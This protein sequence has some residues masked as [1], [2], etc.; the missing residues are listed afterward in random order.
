MMPVLSVAVRRRGLT[1]ILLDT[2]LM[3]GGFFMVIPL[4]AVYYVD[5]LGW[6]ATTIGLVLAV[7]QALQQ[8]LTVIGGALADRFG[9]RRLIWSGLLVRAISFAGLA[10]ADTAP[11]LLATAVL[12]AVGGGL[13]ESPRQA[14]IAAL[15]AP[16]ERRR[17]FALSGVVGGLGMTLGPLLGAALL[18]V[19]FAAVSLVASACFVVAFLVTL[20]ALPPV[21]IA[22]EGRGLTAGVREALADRPFMRYTGL[23]MGYWFLWVQLTIA[24]PLAGRALAGTAD[25]VGWI[26]ALN[27]GMMVCLQLPVLRL[28]ER[29]FSPRTSL[30]LGLVTMAGG[31][32]LI[33]LT[34]SLVGLLVCVAIF[35]FGGLL[36]GPSQ[37]SVTAALANPKALGSYF[38][39]NAL[40]MAFGGGLGNIA[41]GV[42]VDL[43]AAWVLP[44]LPWLVCGVVGLATAAGLSRLRIADH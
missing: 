33:A 30:V 20:V 23:L 32:T 35:S 13:F 5:H 7:R 40:A 14:V 28:V 24:V 38:G 11:A 10:W 31:L 36:A 16:A 18:R 3:F 37:Q 27:A 41:G 19:D 6:A 15:T 4:L 25:V 1:I 8:S 29:R 26:Y 21:P 22:A 12:A 17:F 39:V 34:G 44:A 2:F 42:L 43:A 9:A